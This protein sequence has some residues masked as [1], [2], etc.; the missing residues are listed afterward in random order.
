[1]SDKTKK[2][3]T[4]IIIHD[5]P[6][7]LLGMK[8][9]GL[10]VGRWNGFGGKVHEGETIEEAAHRELMEEAGIKVQ[11]LEKIGVNQFS[12]RNKPEE[13]LEVHVFKS[14][15]FH[16][17]PIETEEM[18]PKWFYA[19][20]IPFGEMWSDDVYW[21]PYFMRG[22]KFHGR[23]TFDEKDKVVDY[24]LQEVDSV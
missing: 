16:G 19:D 18:A 12:W 4:L 1:M 10:G 17:E 22:I 15:S 20:E 8:K 23:Y 5:H 24:S 14:T 7:L 3:T 6:R 21:F 11:N 9:R 2:L 13:I